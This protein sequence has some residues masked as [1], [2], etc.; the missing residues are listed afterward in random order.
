M[1]LK[2]LPIVIV[3]FVVAYHITRLWI[4]CKVY[5]SRLLEHREKKTWID[6]RQMKCTPCIIGATLLTIIVFKSDFRYSVGFRSKLI[7]AKW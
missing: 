1:K 7:A 3:S 2:T 6:S 5:A 4:T